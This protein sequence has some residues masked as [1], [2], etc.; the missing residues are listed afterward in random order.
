MKIAGVVGVPVF[1][2]LLLT[3]GTSQDTFS[4]LGSILEQVASYQLVGAFKPFQLLPLRSYSCC[5]AWHAPSHRHTPWR[6]HVC[7]I[8][9]STCAVY[10]GGLN[11]MFFN[12]RQERTFLD[13]IVGTVSVFLFPFIIYFCIFSFMVSNP[14]SRNLKPP[15]VSA[16]IQEACMCRYSWSVGLLKPAPCT[17]WQ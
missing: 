2:I 3:I 13:H 1:F 10:F 14:L 7:H 9:P 11:Q 15:C 5:G 12:P 16:E 6:W 17:N 4:D 8:A